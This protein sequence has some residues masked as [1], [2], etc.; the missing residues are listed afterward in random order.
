MNSTYG[1]NKKNQ[2]DFKNKIK[3]LFNESH[4]KNVLVYKYFS[5]Y[6]KNLVS[7]I[8]YKID[9]IYTD[10]EGDNQTINE[11]SLRTFKNKNQNNEPDT[12]EIQDHFWV[13]EPI[14]TLK[15]LD[16]IKLTPP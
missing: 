5:I 2:N 15:E 7:F 4:N 6:P 14:R 8:N 13:F 12:E 10:W 9:N 16:N 3:T 11:S 1:N